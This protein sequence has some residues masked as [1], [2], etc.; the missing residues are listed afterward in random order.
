MNLIEL[1][2]RQDLSQNK[3]LNRVYIQ[4]GNLL[5][6]LNKQQLANNITELINQDI[7]EINK[8]DLKGNALLKLVR[9][10]ETKIIT[11]LEKQLKIVPK[12]YYYNHWMTKGMAAFGFPIGVVF[13]L[14]IGNMAMI[15][16]GL[17][18]GV[19]IG[20]AV[21][22]GMDKKASDEGRQLDIEIK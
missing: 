20:A 16:I 18:I 19:A 21:G 3:E 13:G 11:L 5:N 9:Q 15:A 6:E 17:P 2:E 7:V 1:K 14:S 8:T 4:L 22:A 12:K 10:K